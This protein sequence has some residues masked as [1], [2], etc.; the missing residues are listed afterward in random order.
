ML[1]TAKPGDSLELLLTESNGK[2]AFAVATRPEAEGGK[3]NASTS[4]TLSRTGQLISTLFSGTPEAKGR[5]QP[6]ALN[7]NQPILNTPPGSEQDLLPMLKQ[8]ITQTSFFY[9]SHQPEWVQGRLPKAALLQEPQG[10]LSSP[11]AFT[12]T[13]ETTNSEL[14][15]AALLKSALP[16][17]QTQLSR[18]EGNKANL[19]QSIGEMIAPQTQL[20]VQQQLQALAT[21]NFAR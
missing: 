11:A 12:S 14:T 17:K 6:V 5:S 7:G 18:V 19:P 21:H 16:G 8:A 20:L 13:S 9:E 10:K 3:G 4:A 15:R 2:L 1:F